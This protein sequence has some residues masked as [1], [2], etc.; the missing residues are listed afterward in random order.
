[1]PGKRFEA[2]GD[3]NLLA[4]EVVTNVTRFALGR[5][6]RAMDAH[7]T[8]LHNH[9]YSFPN[10]REEPPRR[11]K[12]PIAHLLAVTSRAAFPMLVLIAAASQVNRLRWGRF[13]W[14]EFI[15]DCTPMAPVR[16]CPGL[17][18]YK[19]ASSIGF[20]DVSLLRSG[21]S[22]GKIIAA[23]EFNPHHDSRQR[24]AL[25]R[26]CEKRAIIA[27]VC[28]RASCPACARQIES[29]H[30][31]LGPLPP[32]APVDQKPPPGENADAGR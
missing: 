24:V 17:F 4:T 23:M 14:R 18:G 30:H 19:T 2:G 26:C 32:L 10:F 12:Y 28:E 1:M 20:R 16:F 9:L 15:R 3:V 25:E 8:K 27:A 31:L 13:R 21:F 29:H 11:Y 5:E 7:G 6:G 22:R